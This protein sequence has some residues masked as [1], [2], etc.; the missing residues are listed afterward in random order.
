MQNDRS[1][2]VLFTFLSSFHV[3]SK[4]HPSD[5]A[6]VCVVPASI[7]RM[8]DEGRVVPTHGDPSVHHDRV[9]RVPAVA[10]ETRSNILKTTGA[11]ARGATYRTHLSEAG[12][13]G[14]FGDLREV[15]GF[16]EGDRAVQFSR[17]VAASPEPFKAD[18]Q[19]LRQRDKFDALKNRFFFFLKCQL[20]DVRVGEEEGFTHVD[21][22]CVPHVGQEQQF[23]PRSSC[24]SKCDVRQCS[25]MTRLALASAVSCCQY[26]GDI[27][28]VSLGLN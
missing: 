14:F 3:K 17:L 21:G 28:R 25:W 20:L 26:S 16:W 18:A 23:R 10:L 24:C 6:V 15:K 5:V 19:N 2:P 22:V 7:G 27:Q 13:E 12:R 4:T 8:A 9:Q 1:K 11:V